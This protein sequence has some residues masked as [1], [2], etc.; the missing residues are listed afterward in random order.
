VLYAVTSAGL[1]RSSDGGRTWSAAGDV[2][3]GETIVALNSPDVLYAGAHQP[4]AKGGA[5]TVFTRSTDGGKTWQS[6]DAGAGVQPLLALAGTHTKVVGSSCA[7]V[8]SADGGQTFTPVSITTNYDTSGAASNDP[9]L[10][11]IVVL[12]TSE[13]GTT[14]LRKLDVSDFSAPADDG[15]L[16]T[17]FG[18]GA[19]VWAGDRI[20]LATPEGVG[21]SADNGAT[22]NWSRAGLEQVTFS[23]DPLTDAIPANEQGQPFGFSVARV[24]PTDPQRVWVGG[25]LGAWRS[26]D[27]GQTWTQLGDNSRID[28]LVVS[29]A[30]GRV[31][32]SSDGGTRMWTLDGQ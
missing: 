23:V 12:G 29:T 27:G 2:Q 14:Q 21:I 20:V 11:R 16:A 7:L 17:F 26:A 9:A 3:A 28:S 8:L 19:V 22:W 15:V 31:F 13:G 5:A 25:E 6:F 1:S 10:T 18:A 30:A 32:V 4:C 24:D